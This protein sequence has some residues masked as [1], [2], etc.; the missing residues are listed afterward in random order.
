MDND[1]GKCDITGKP[2]KAGDDCFRVEVVRLYQS[3]GYPSEGTVVTLNLCADAFLSKT[4]K[5]DVEEAM[6]TRTRSPY[7][8]IPSAEVE[9]I[10]KAKAYILNIYKTGDDPF[11]HVP[12]GR[13]FNEIPGLTWELMITARDLIAPEV[14]KLTQKASPHT[15]I[16]E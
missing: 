2:F 14:Y 10:E 5:R 8:I 13:I 1:Y 15:K 4:L 16:S 11:N 12:N 6:T 7:R 3:Q 9:I